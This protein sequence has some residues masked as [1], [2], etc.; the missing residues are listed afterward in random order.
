M[1]DQ[2]SHEVTQPINGEGEANQASGTP[3]LWPW[4]PHRISMK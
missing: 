1:Q 4:L 3:A 2:E